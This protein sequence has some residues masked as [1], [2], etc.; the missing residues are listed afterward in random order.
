MLLFFKI[1]KQKKNYI[2]TSG[3]LFLRVQ[4]QL[5]QQLQQKQLKRIVKSPPFVQ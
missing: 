5:Q 1:H 2:V 3:C 4:Q